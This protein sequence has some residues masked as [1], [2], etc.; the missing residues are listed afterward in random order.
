MAERVGSGPLRYLRLS[1]VHLK[2]NEEFLFHAR[3]IVP[4]VEPDALDVYVERYDQPVYVMARIDERHDYVLRQMQFKP[5]LDFFE[6]RRDLFRLWM[7]MGGASAGEPGHESLGTS[8]VT[9][10]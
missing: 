6:D 2:P 9:D 5:L 1:R 7:R 8:R 4:A 10:A 3:R